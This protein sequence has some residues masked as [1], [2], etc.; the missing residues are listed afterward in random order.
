MRF[1][2]SLSTVLAADTSTAFGAQSAFRQIVD[3][4][5]RGR[6]TVTPAL[7]ARLEALRPMVPAAVR[8]ASARGLALGCPPEPLVA[9][10]AADEPSVAAAA[11]RA[12]TL[13]EAQWDAL[14]PKVGPTGRAILRGRADLPASAKRSLE[15]FGAIDFTIGFEASELQT[16]GDPVSLPSEQ[17]VPSPPPPHGFPIAELVDRLA[18]FQRGESPERAEPRP[19]TG[20]T[21]ETDA[22]GGIRWTDAE[23]RS[24]LLGTRLTGPLADA[25]HRR[26]SVRGAAL[27]LPAGTDLSGDWDVHGFPVFDA[28]ARY[29]GLRGTARRTEAAVG[30]SGEAIRRLVHELRTPMNAISGFAELMGSE[31]LGPVA[32]AHRE[33]AGAIHADMAALLG[34]I[35]DLDV[36]ARID[37]R[38]LDLAPRE[39][40]VW[41]LLESYRDR[42]V[43]TGTRG[44][45]VHADPRAFGRIVDRFVQLLDHG[46][47]VDV[48][49]DGCWSTLAADPPGADGSGSD[50]RGAPLLGTDFTLRLIGDLARELGGVFA[51]GE[52]LTLRLPSRLNQ[53]VRIGGRT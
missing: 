43:P 41:A 45:I 48:A 46:A 4:L 10:F 35:E 13:E 7:I 23:P 9:F 39:I 34:A 36:A 37:G 50:S 28:D 53:E 20:F 42:I 19:S 6:V 5:G 21:F 25:C 44:A 1:D 16:P 11:L 51:P 17:P 30:S 14:L 22:R 33:A 18:A 31:L 15:A 40:A 49:D 29:V 12:V 38:A 8:A 52:R 26:R 2:D 3:L 24:A 47:R 27:R 32:P